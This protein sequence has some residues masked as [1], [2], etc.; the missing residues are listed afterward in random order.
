MSSNLSLDAFRSMMGKH[1]L[2]TIGLTND[3]NGNCTLSKAD[4]HASWLLGRLFNAKKPGENSKVGS[5]KDAR[6]ALYKAF[7]DDIAKKYGKEGGTGGKGRSISETEKQSR[8]EFMDLL[9]KELLGDDK[10]TA[11]LSRNEDVARLLNEYDAR[12]LSWKPISGRALRVRGS[13]KPE[14]IRS[15]YAQSVH[16]EALK[17]LDADKISSSNLAA[18]G[19]LADIS[20]KEV[21]TLLKTR[22]KA[23][24]EFLETDIRLS[25]DG[26]HVADMPVSVLREHNKVTDA[27]L[28]KEITKHDLVMA[29]LGRAIYYVKTGDVPDDLK[30]VLRLLE[31]EEISSQKTRQEGIALYEA[32]LKPK[33]AE[34]A[35]VPQ[36]P[37]NPPKPAENA[38]VP[39]V[40]QNQPKPAVKEEKPVDEVKKAAAPVPGDPIKEGTAR[41][42]DL[43]RFIEFEAERFSLYLFDEKNRKILTDGNFKDVKIPQ[44]E[45][46]QLLKTFI[47][48]LQKESE[49]LEQ[50]TRNFEALKTKG[51]TQ[52]E[53]DKL[54]NSV[55][56]K[57]AKLQN[58]PAH[59][60][61]TS[62]ANSLVR[63]QGVL[64]GVIA[65]HE[66]DKLKL[67][68]GHCSW[69]NIGPMLACNGSPYD[70]QVGAGITKETV[71]NDIKAALAEKDRIFQ[72]A[73]EE[74]RRLG[75]DLRTE[76]IKEH[77]SDD[78]IKALSK[79]LDDDVNNL[80]EETQKKLKK[81]VGDDF[82]QK[83]AKLILERERK[84][85]EELGKSTKPEDK[86]LYA[87]MTLALQLTQN[88]LVDP[89][90]TVTHLLMDSEYFFKELL[91]PQGL[92]PELADKFIAK[93]F[94]V[95]GDKITLEVVQGVQRMLKVYL[96][97]EGT[98]RMCHDTELNLK[99]FPQ[100]GEVLTSGVLDKASDRQ[101][102][103]FL[104][105]I[106][107]NKIDDADG[108]YR[109][110]W[111]WTGRSIP[112]FFENLNA[113]GMTLDKLPVVV[114]AAKTHMTYAMDVLS[115]LKRM[116]GGSSYR[117]DAFFERVFGKSPD[118][119]SY[120]DVVKKYNSW[121][122]GKIVDPQKKL[123]AAQQD[124]IGFV[125]GDQTFFSRLG[126]GA[127]KTVKAG[128]KSL[129]QGLKSLNGGK[130]SVQV[131]FNGKDALLSR[132]EDDSLSLTVGKAGLEIPCKISASALQAALENELFSHAKDF[133]FDMLRPFVPYQTDTS[134]AARE[135]FLRLAVSFAD[136]NA[137]ELSQVKTER[138]AT[139]AYD[140]LNKT[141][142]PEDV[143]EIVSKFKAEV[144]PEG[145]VKADL[146]YDVGSM[147]VIEAWNKADQDEKDAIVFNA[148]PKT[149]D[150]KL[151]DFVADLVF[152]K[153]GWIYDGFRGKGGS[154]RIADVFKRHPEAVLTVLRDPSRLTEMIDLKETGLPELAQNFINMQLKGA[155]A[156]LK[157]LLPRQIKALDANFDTAKLEGDAPLSPDEKA[158]YDKAI[159]KI[160]E[161]TA[162]DEKAQ[163]DYIFSLYPEE[164]EGV[165]SAQKEY[166]AASRNYEN[167]AGLKRVLFLVPKTNAAAKLAMAELK[168]VKPLKGLFSTLAS[169]DQRLGEV[170]DTVA[171]NVQEKIND[172]IDELLGQVDESVL[173][174]PVWQQSLAEL[175]NAGIVDPNSGYGLFLRNAAKIYFKNM[176]SDDRRAMLAAGIRHSAGAEG[177]AGLASAIVKGLGPLMQKILQG[178]PE[179]MLPAEF[180]GAVKDVKSRLAPIPEEYVKAQLLQLKRKSGGKI[181]SIEVKQVLGA[182]SVGEALLCRVKTKDNPGGKDLVVKILRPD[183]KMRLLREQKTF[184]EAAK[185]SGEGMEVTY[186]GQLR[187]IKEEFDFLLEADNIVKGKAYDAPVFNASNPSEFS[188]V[189]SMK[190]NA[191]CPPSTDVLVLEKAPGVTV[192]NLLEASEKLRTELVEKNTK[193]VEGQKT[194]MFNSSAAYQDTVKQLKA[195]YDEIRDRQI[196]VNDLAEAWVEEAI[197]RGGFFHG[198]LHAGNMLVDGLTGVT[199]IDYGNATKLNKNEQQAMMRMSVYAGVQDA[200]KFL[201]TFIST[202]TP[203]GQAQINSNNKKAK[204]LEDIKEIFAKGTSRDIAARMFGAFAI[205]QREEI[206]TPP[207]VYN[208]LQSMMRLSGTLDAM[209]AE[210]NKIKE[211]LLK[212]ERP[213]GV[214]AQQVEFDEACDFMDAVQH[215]LTLSRILAY[216]PVQ[217]SASLAKS[218]KAINDNYHVEQ[219]RKDADV[220]GARTAY[221]KA[222]GGPSLEIQDVL[223]RDLGETFLPR[224]FLGLVA[225]PGWSEK[226]EAL[227]MFKQVFACN[228]GRPVDQLVRNANPKPSDEELRQAMGYVVAHH[229]ARYPEIAKAVKS[230]TQKEYDAL[231]KTPVLVDGVDYGEKAFGDF[232]DALLDTKTN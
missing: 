209:A 165:R 1:N 172:G 230:L 169:L 41:L 208:F 66:L 170:A 26:V 3:K 189:R 60:K 82:Q 183:A 11:A 79:K 46:G 91:G 223:D 212:T 100:I 70:E 174:T 15:V 117:L 114:H 133:G 181:E 227:E 42:A 134:P 166:D 90:G 119:V 92:R 104:E 106:H 12:R 220:K 150:Q 87:K 152:N 37:Q 147:E 131:R 222:H 192:D 95:P 74:L 109:A 56:D 40:P 64:N 217:D 204:V 24:K 214:P 99:R 83:T 164:Q 89:L 57:I 132:K 63:A 25:L 182:A 141:E 160:F 186:E 98:L 9:K 103:Y 156:S 197:F 45:E 2:G 55:Q 36:V 210:M 101:L 118:D 5:N 27:L 105:S 71:E 30:V 173:H 67:E 48:E 116:N 190:A 168:V 61:F 178:I 17:I 73:N 175:Q 211:V 115:M 13:G 143:Q 224:A 144:A 196:R 65:T 88:L 145:A 75:A 176:S 20:K 122:A 232:L 34:N 195:K 108:I 39:Q 52:D 94:G 161:V 113:S 142:S 81:A 47:D 193:A 16:D 139:F 80:V 157:E 121:M 76:L 177:E 93:T 68:H 49:I 158:T 28:S 35:G 78:R 228:F 111:N 8:K 219:D 19:V 184:I 136:V 6:E 14:T 155:L 120:N 226:P 140:L 171:D 126:K 207:S 130:N 200:E 23:I 180:Q 194:R 162:L 53:V 125:N 127:D 135:K 201:D 216:L 51:C 138:L 167:A 33:P 179:S 43:K 21:E 203:K 149:E 231:R 69:E 29:A 146:A 137:L 188:K 163:T 77:P 84:I 191:I 206:E 72:E 202:L 215:R 107:Y 7:E 59:Q 129:L 4:N 44:G 213:Q 112:E 31:A 128:M 96:G 185:A 32:R 38:E 102:L 18:M 123:S 218:K 159:A 124:L 86:L 62:P 199:V 148:P 153:E 85:Y 198:D 154:D 221:F 10:K 58:A 187:R 97:D 205:I 22:G 50:A 151:H 229:M 225:R 54:M 110:H